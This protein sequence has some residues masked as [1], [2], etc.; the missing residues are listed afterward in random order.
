MTVIPQAQKIYKFWF[1]N[2]GIQYVFNADGDEWISLQ[3]WQHSE[4]QMWVCTFS[5][6]YG[7][8]IKNLSTA[9]WMSFTSEGWMTLEGY[10]KECES[11]TFTP[12]RDGGYRM[13]VCLKG[14]RNDVRRYTED[15]TDFVG[16]EQ[17]ISSVSVHLEE[18]PIC[19]LSPY[20]RKVFSCTDLWG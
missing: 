19:E 17:Q 7:L 5:K 6:K 10:Q 1:N 15:Q 11:F 18:I 16:C 3:P 2:P 13:S 20:V 12:L 9:K 4:R 14:A 8:G